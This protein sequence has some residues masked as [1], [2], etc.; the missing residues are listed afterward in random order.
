MSPS[1]EWAAYQFDMYR[2]GMRNFSLQ[3][4]PEISI[5]PD[6]SGQFWLDADLDVSGFD[7]QGAKMNLSAVIEE[8]DGTKSYWALAHAPG[9]PDFHNSDCFIATLPAPTAP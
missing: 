2:E 9:P 3:S 8:R 1:F 7:A 4:D 5:T 6:T